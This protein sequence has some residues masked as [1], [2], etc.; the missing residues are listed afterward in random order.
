MRD[1][2]QPFEKT[3]LVPGVVLCALAIGHVFYGVLAWTLDASWLLDIGQDAPVGLSTLAWFL[4]AAPLLGLVGWLCLWGVR[5]GQRPLPR[6]FGWAVGAVSLTGAVIWPLS[7]FPV[8]VL[9]G[10]YIILGKR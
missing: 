8:G 10:V 5:A 1:P 2:R 4:A 6:S 9:L 3:W 7:G